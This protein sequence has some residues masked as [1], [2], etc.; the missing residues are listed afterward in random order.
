MGRAD[1]EFGDILAARSGTYA[2]VSQQDATDSSVGKA[3]FSLGVD[4]LGDDDIAVLLLAVL[5]RVL[6]GLEVALDV[7]P[8]RPEIHTPPGPAYSIPQENPQE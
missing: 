7:D 3:A 8:S 2:R 4:A 5:V 6:V 1:T